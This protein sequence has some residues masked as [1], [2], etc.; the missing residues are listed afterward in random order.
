MCSKIGTFPSEYF[1]WLSGVIILKTSYR[2]HKP[3]K[4]CRPVSPLRYMAQKVLVL[5]LWKPY[6]P[7]FLGP[8]TTNVPVSILPRAGPGETQSDPSAEPAATVQGP[9][10]CRMTQKTAFRSEGLSG[11]SSPLDR[12][13]VFWAHMVV[14][15]T[16]SLEVVGLRFWLSCWLLGGSCSQ[17]PGAALRVLPHGPLPTRQLI[18]SRK[19]GESLFL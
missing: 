9:H 1:C 14:G 10:C 18:S 17:L 11:L 16:Q 12:R 19:A 5:R 6:S 15:W 2:N 4:S 3:T 8:G 13:I 7:L